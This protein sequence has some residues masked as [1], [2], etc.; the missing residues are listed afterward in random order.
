[1]IPAGGSGK[2]IAK[3]KTHATQRGHITKIVTVTT[4][5]PVAKT[6]QLRVSFEPEPAIDIKP[7]PQVRLEV[8]EGQAGTQKVVLHRTDG[9]PLEVT[10]VDT[11][12][13]KLFEV[14]AVPVKKAN[15]SLGAVAGDVVLEVSAAPRKGYLSRSDALIIHT[16]HPKMASFR[17]PVTLRVNP[18]I[19]ATPAQLRLW[20]GPHEVASGIHSIL[21]LRSNIKRPF[22]VVSV[23]SSQPEL[24]QVG[25]TRP[26]AAV[27][28]SL[29]VSV[30]AKAVA[31][32]GTGPVRAEITVRTDDPN[33]PEIKVPAFVRKR[34][35]FEP[36][37]IGVGGPRKVQPGNLSTIRMK[38][39]LVE[40]G[41]SRPTER[42]L[43]P[44]GMR[45]ASPA[46]KTA[47]PT[48]APT[49][50]AGGGSS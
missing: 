4:D 12:S 11:G 43:R 41:S 10:G 45:P 17:L 24:I 2:L 26:E 48:P 30:P 42:R 21:V 40:G 9:Q 35:G 31:S 16:N 28:H 44:T 36:K 38:K 18:L 13:S 27:Q 29:Q 46:T 33:R 19:Q 37:G 39:N 3:V 20:A 8:L 5:D 23:T 34:G 50:G 1:M 7:R 14:K 25:A 47:E 15:P 22:R 49:P 32:L 6:I